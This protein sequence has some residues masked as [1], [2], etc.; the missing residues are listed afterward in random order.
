MAGTALERLD[1]A[2]GAIAPRDPDTERGGLGRIR[3]CSSVR[4]IAAVRRSPTGPPAVRRL[5]CL[6][7]VFAGQS[8]RLPPGRAR[9]HGARI[10]RGGRGTREEEERADPHRAGT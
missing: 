3:I 7:L 4:A 8:P 6:Q 2:A 9:E 1:P 10:A 5:P